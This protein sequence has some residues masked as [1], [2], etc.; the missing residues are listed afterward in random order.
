M[1]FLL[2]LPVFLTF[3]RRA[4]C[5]QEWILWENQDEHTLCFLS[6]NLHCSLA[7]YLVV[8]SW[9]TKFTNKPYLTQAFL[10][11][12][13]RCHKPTHLGNQKTQLS[14]WL[15]PLLKAVSHDLYKTTTLLRLKTK[16]SGENISKC[17]YGF[18]EGLHPRQ[19]VSNV[20]DREHHSVPLHASEVLQ[21]TWALVKGIQARK[22]GD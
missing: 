7:P 18:C 16:T 9:Y 10:V 3:Y 5:K 22:P 13:E 15:M 14:V 20:W 11:W 2:L 19:E 17:K 4:Q 21:N 6:Q 1:L 12:K 8:S